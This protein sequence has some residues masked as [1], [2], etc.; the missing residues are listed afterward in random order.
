M[1][2]YKIDVKKTGIGWKVV[3]SKRWYIFWIPNTIVNI[4]QGYE[5]LVDKQINDW[6]SHFNIPVE[7]VTIHENKE[8]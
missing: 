4:S 5:Y 8:D 6:I 7:K 3:L 1:G 2:K